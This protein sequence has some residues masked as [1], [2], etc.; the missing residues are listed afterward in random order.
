MF[1]TNF[2][3][4]ISITKSIHLKLTFFQATYVKCCKNRNKRQDKNCQHYKIN[5]SKWNCTFQFY[6]NMN[7]MLNSFDR[8]TFPDQLRPPKQKNKFSMK[9]LAQRETDPAIRVW[10]SQQQMNI[11]FTCRQKNVCNLDLFKFLF[12]KNQRHHPLEEESGSYTLL[13]SKKEM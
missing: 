6:L 2:A 10:F 3:N 12:S 5:M 13:L 1:K 4:A 9:R 7:D 8:C 11:S